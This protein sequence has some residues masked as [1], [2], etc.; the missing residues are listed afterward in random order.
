[1]Q[2]IKETTGVDALGVFMTQQG[3]SNWWWADDIFLTVAWG[4]MANDF[5]ME[6]Y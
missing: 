4:D 3:W 6:K 5:Y 1:M 2:K